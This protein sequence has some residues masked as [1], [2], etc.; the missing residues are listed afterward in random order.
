MSGGGKIDCG[1]SPPGCPLDWNA[2]CVI[3]PCSCKPIWMNEDIRTPSDACLHSLIAKCVPEDECPMEFECLPSKENFK[4]TYNL[5]PE[6]DVQCVMETCTCMPSWKIYEVNSGPLVIPG[7]H[8]K[9]TED[10]PKCCKPGDYKPNNCTSMIKPS[11][12]RCKSMRCV[13][14]KVNRQTCTIMDPCDDCN[15]KAMSK[16][17]K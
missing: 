4:D 11:Q 3:D 14:V 10:E 5:P 16:K 6:Y 7:F 2:R 17:S 15:I 1:P 13:G 12:D 8:Q 9:C